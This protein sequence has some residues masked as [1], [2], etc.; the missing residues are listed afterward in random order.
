MELIKVLLVFAMI[1][2][3]LGIT[4][5]S[6]CSNTRSWLSS[7]AM[8]YSCFSTK[9]DNFEEVKLTTANNIH[10]VN[11]KTNDD[12]KSLSIG[13]EK[14]LTF[15]PK[16]IQGIFPTFNELHFDGCPINE[17]KS[18]DLSEYTELNYF[19]ITG[20]K[21]QHI[22]NDFLKAT[23]K[24]VGINF[25]ENEIERIE[26]EFLQNLLNI[27]TLAYVNFGFNKCIKDELEASTKEEI[28]KVIVKLRESCLYVPTTTTTS[29]TPT[30]ESTCTTDSNDAFVIKGYTGIILI[31]LIYNLMQ[32]F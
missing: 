1:S 17:L 16:K 30:T 14:N 8:V 4:L 26:E 7:S 11:G 3:C 13:Q 27:S 22:P 10:K 32:K 15:I 21:I 31:S 20:T 29:T 5:E 25:S 12:V 6:F 28:N 24:I 2:S 9:L 18:D 23:Q 19:G